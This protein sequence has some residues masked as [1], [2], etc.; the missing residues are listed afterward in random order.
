MV[1]LGIPLIKDY[2]GMDEYTYVNQFYPFN[3]SSNEPWPFSKRF[4]SVQVSDKSVQYLSDWSIFANVLQIHHIP[5]VLQIIK[6][7]TEPIDSFTAWLGWT[8]DAWSENQMTGNFS[9]A[10]GMVWA[11]DVMPNFATHAYMQLELPMTNPTHVDTNNLPDNTNKHT[12]S[13][14]F[15]DGDSICADAEGIF[16]RY[17]MP[18]RGDVPI[19]W[20]LDPSLAHL[21]PGIL[22]M[23]YD[24]ATVNDSFIAFAPGYAYPDFMDDNDRWKWAQLAGEAMVAADMSVN[25]FIGFNYSTE[26]FGPVL[27]QW[28]VAGV[29]YF[30]YP[31]YY[32]LT[33]NRNGTVTWVHNKPSIA[34]RE[35]LWDGHSTPAYIASVLNSQKR[36]S[37][38]VDGYSVIAVHV[39]SEDV[40]SIVETV[41]ALDDDI[42]VVNLDVLV[43]L[44]TQ[45]VVDKT[46]PPSKSSTAVVES[47]HVTSM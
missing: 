10:G 42:M 41:K 21:A 5:T 30:D 38:T 9:Q 45:N 18:A 37:T 19:S 8:A 36:D 39:W 34:V 26:F 20:G 25:Y 16:Q 40:N 7:V 32:L 2:R 13:F 3:P 14:L 4:F 35:S 23:Y 33:D 29:V 47:S 24:H 43:A 17:T 31:N 22:Q 12:V 11:A 27:S 46:N 44:M 1:G 6:Q 28:N 15:T